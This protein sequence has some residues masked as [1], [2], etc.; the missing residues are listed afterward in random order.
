MYI[1]MKINIKQTQEIDTVICYIQY[2]N[3]FAIQ[4]N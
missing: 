2:I 4:I 3:M 1:E